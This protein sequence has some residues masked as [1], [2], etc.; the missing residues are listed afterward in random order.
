MKNIAKKVAA[1][2]H[3]DDVNVRTRDIGNPPKRGVRRMNRKWAKRGR[4]EE[5]A[6]AFA[7]AD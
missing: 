3:K 2:G 6:L 4:R 7:D 1:A 5:E